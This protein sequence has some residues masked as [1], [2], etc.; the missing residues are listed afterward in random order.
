M[1]CSEHVADEIIAYEAEEKHICPELE[2]ARV[3]FLSLCAPSVEFWLVVVIYPKYMWDNQTS[4]ELDESTISYITPQPSLHVVASSQRHRKKNEVT[5]MLNNINH[6]EQ[7]I[8]N[9]THTQTIQHLTPALSLS[10]PVRHPTKLLLGP[11]FPNKS[12]P[13]VS[14]HRERKTDISRIGERVDRLGAFLRSH[15]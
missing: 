2:T 7:H 1:P 11:I 6:N 13:E 14:R 12:G 8:T 9:R 4:L 10:H 15:P 5:T 3:L